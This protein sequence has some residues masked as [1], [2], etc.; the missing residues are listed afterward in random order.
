MHLFDD[1]PQG[2]RTYLKGLYSEL[3]LLSKS[4]FIF[5]F[6]A[7]DID[8]L[9][10]VFGN[11]ENVIYVKL[12]RRNSLYRL[13]IDIPHLIKKYKIDYSHFQYIS[14]FVKTGK[15]I[16]TIHD[17]LFEQNEFKNFFP[18]K[19]RM[20]NSFF[21]RL[22]ARKADILLTVSE[23]SKIKISEIYKI[24][25]NKIHVTTNAVEGE[26]ENIVSNQKP[27]SFFHE[28]YIL[29]VSR[30]EPRKNHLL[31]IKAFLDLKLYEEGFKLILIGSFDFPGKEML[32]FIKK[33]Q[34]IL[35]NNVIWKQNVSHDDIRNYYKN[36]ELFVFPSLAE[37]FGIP[38]LE[39]L[40][41]NKKVLVS[42]S[43][44]MKDFNLPKELSFNPYDIGDLKE[45]IRE[46]LYNNNYDYKEEYLSILNNFNWRISASV[47]FHL[48]K[49]DD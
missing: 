4:T 25:L 6:L 18:L 23:Y 13:L 37:G 38:V 9:Q 17:I 5:H 27:S 16:I 28:K 46:L 2:S 7:Y 48:I 10:K 41:F 30:V 43:T 44:A 26:F 20:I 34:D 8:N 29:Y 49:N 19:Y 22:S 24:P 3:I 21:F 14:P 1:R 15:Y 32:K 47:L 42:N 35:E 33:N 31:L 45:K 39:A 40:R 36:C 11:H 12:K